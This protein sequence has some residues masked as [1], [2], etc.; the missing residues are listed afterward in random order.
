MTVRGEQDFVVFFGSQHG[1][2][3]AD[4]G[5]LRDLF[6]GVNRERAE[7]V[8]P[9]EQRLGGSDAPRQCLGTARHVAL[10]FHPLEIAVEVFGGD[11]AESYVFWEKGGKQAHIREEGFDRV[12]R[13]SLIGEVHLPRFDRRNKRRVLIEV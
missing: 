11:F 7:L 6:R 2:N 3:G 4:G 9:A 5:A 13:T 10:F 12:R 8:Q 1:G